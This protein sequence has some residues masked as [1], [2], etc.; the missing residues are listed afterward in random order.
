[1]KN[2]AHLVSAA[3]SAPINIVIATEEE[4]MEAG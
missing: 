1:M 3:L 4:E 2:S